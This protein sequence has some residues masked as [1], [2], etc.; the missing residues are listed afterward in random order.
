MLTSLKK[1]MSVFEAKTKRRA[2][3]LLVLMI[4][5]AIAE[6]ASI[7]LIFPLVQ[8]ISDAEAAKSNQFIQMGMQFFEIADINSVILP[9]FALTFLFFVGKNL[10]LIFVVYVQGRFIWS[11]LIEFWIRLYSIYL[12]SSYPF[13]LKNNSADLVT[14]ITVSIRNM[15]YSLVMPA[16]NLAVEVLTIIAIG[17]LLL[18]ISP[19]IT[20]ASL[21]ILSSAVAA[22]HFLFRKRLVY[23][24]TDQIHH[25]K[26]MLLW[27]NQGLR[28][29]KEIK[30]LGRGKYFLN[31]FAH[32]ATIAGN[33][34]RRNLLI[35]QLP[36]YLVEIVIVTIV[37][38]SLFVIQS[39]GDI[40]NILPVLS[41]FGLAA[42]RLMPSMS[43]IST[44]F[45]NMEFGTGALEAVYADITLLKEEM[46]FQQERETGIE[47]PF[48]R[49]ICVRDL[50]F[51]F[52]DAEIAALHNLNFTIK[53]GETIG[54]VG[55]SGAGKTTLADLMLGLL[56]PTSGSI[57]V[58]GQSIYLNV[59]AWQRRV[60]CVPQNVHLIDDTLR[61]NIA[62]GV[63]R[64]K[65]DDNQVTRAVTLSRLT[66]AVGNMP[67]GLDT[68]IGEQGVR[69]SGGQRQRVGIARSLYF[70]AEVL[71][72]D[73]ATSALD[74]ETEHSISEAVNA[75][76]GDKTII[77]IAHRLSTVRRCDR[78]YFM[79]N[80]A[81]EASGSFDELVDKNAQFRDM[82]EKMNVSKQSEASD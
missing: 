21:V 22:Y 30:I 45:S 42:F 28:G 23:W 61:S 47:I 9:I 8:I 29:I 19:Q 55:P 41:V 49:D 63:E 67:H 57:E 58:D 4:L 6:A 26:K 59:R 74:S 7:G 53:K 77:I 68:E 80:G 46:R 14:N 40:E 50:S 18:A 52:P 27:L 25:N 15:F 24:G 76:Q 35:V 33:H 12:E 11:S 2:L 70:D 17:T 56:E 10:F 69:L 37:L 5:G 79:N 65:I 36:R 75:L 54:F 1:V 20:M 44:Y 34:S 73:E 66:E 39:T 64:K 71:F 81:I 72:L 78:L 60:G 3:G 51:R 43:R 38:G 13:H 32:S 16:I 82:V 62:L 48:T 31:S